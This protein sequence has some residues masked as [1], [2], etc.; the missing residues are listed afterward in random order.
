MSQTLF[1]PFLP[2][3][4]R[5]SILFLLLLYTNYVDNQYS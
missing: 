5:L 4:Y 1:L 3:L 2:P